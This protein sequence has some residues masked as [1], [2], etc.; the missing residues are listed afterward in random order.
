MKKI[1]MG[2]LI[3][4]ISILFIVSMAFAGETCESKAAAKKLVGNAKISFIKKCEDNTKTV[5]KN[6]SREANTNENN[7]T[8]IAKSSLLKI[9]FSMHKLNFDD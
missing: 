1:L 2:V 6:V 8:S 5:N 9:L 4:S 7:M 3:A